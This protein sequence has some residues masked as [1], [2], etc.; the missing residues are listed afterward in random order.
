MNFFSYPKNFAGKKKP[1]V[2]DLSY[3]VHKNQ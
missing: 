2:T 3:A 1:N